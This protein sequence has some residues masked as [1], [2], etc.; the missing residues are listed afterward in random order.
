MLSGEKQ[1]KGR[2]AGS[3]LLGV[4]VWPAPKGCPEGK[5]KPAPQADGGVQA[6]PLRSRHQVERHL[7]SGR[8]PSQTLKGSIIHKP[9]DAIQFGFA[10]PGKG[11]LLGMEPSNHAVSILVRSPLPGVVGAGKIHVHVSASGDFLMMRKLLT[12]VECDS[13]PNLL[14]QCLEQGADNACDLCGFLA[15]RTPNQRKPRSSLHQRD[16]IPGLMRPVDQIAFPV[17]DGLSRIHLSW[18]RVDHALIRNLP[19]SPPIL[20]GAATM[21]LALGTGKV[22]PQCPSGLGLGVDVLVNRL[23]RY[24]R[25]PLHAGSVSNHIRRPAIFDPSFG[26]NPDLLSEAPWPRPQSPRRCL[27]LFGPV[28][29]KTRVAGYLTRN[30]ARRSLQSSGRLTNPKPFLLPPLNED[31]FSS[32]HAFVSHLVLLVL[33]HMKNVAYRVTF[34][35][36]RCCISWLRAGFVSR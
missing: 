31:T 16:Q 35:Y 14:R 19:S 2:Y 32:G 33:S 20:P 3:H 6:L 26:I 25:S 7:L 12:V 28:V 27:C 13:R 34:S 36:N 9:V 1:A 4:R 30:T 8:H 11:R 17:P 23:L 10:Y 15:V 22:R 21:P 18:T 5:A 24:P 29:A